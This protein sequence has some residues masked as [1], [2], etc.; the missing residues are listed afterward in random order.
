MHKSIKQRLAALEAMHAEH[1]RR[2]MEKWA[3]ACRVAE[4]AMSFSQRQDFEAF[5]EANEAQSKDEHLSLVQPDDPNRLLERPA[6]VLAA[7]YDAVL[8]FGT[9]FWPAYHAQG[10]TWDMVP[11]PLYEEATHAHS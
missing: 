11:F 8:A 5:C 4:A 7:W 6:W 1:V 9:A 10:G 2:E 3:A